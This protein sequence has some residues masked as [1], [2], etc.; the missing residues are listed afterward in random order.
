[1]GKQMKTFAFGAK[2]GQDDNGEKFVGVLSL[3][4]PEIAKVNHRTHHVWILDR[5]HSLSGH[6]HQLMDQVRAAAKTIPSEDLLSV[7]YFAGVG[8]HAPVII[9]AQFDEIDPGC[10]LFL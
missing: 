4:K 6:I 1:M 5:S 8:V 2:I 10:N 3:G 9:G 7:L